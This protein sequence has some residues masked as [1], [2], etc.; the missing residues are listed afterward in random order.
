ME[1]SG[2]LISNSM[3]EIRM[4]KKALL[5]L[6]IILLL[7]TGVPFTNK[8]SSDDCF[9]Q[10]VSISLNQASLEIGE[11]LQLNVVY[12]LYYDISNP[13]GI[14]SVTVTINNQAES[15]TLRLVE[16]T[17]IGLDIQKIVELDILPDDW[18][19]YETGQ[20]GRI[21][22]EGWVQ[23]SGGTMTDSVEQQFLVQRS[24]LEITL[25]P[26]PAQI[27]FHDTINFEGFL[28]NPHNTS[29][30]VPNHPIIILATTEGQLVQSW[31]QNTTQQSNF[32]QN[33]D[34][35]LLGTGSFDCNITTLAN[36]DY[37][38]NWSLVSFF[39]SN[40]SLTLTALSN[41]S[42]V[43][44]YYPSMNNCSVLVSAVL[45]CTT[46]SHTFEGNTVTCR[47]RNQTE[48]MNYI[49][50]NLFSTELLVPNSPGNYSIVITVNAP[51]HELINTTIP[52]QVE[53]RQ[54]LMIFEANQSIAAYGDKIGFTLTVYDYW[55]RIPVE[56]KICSI[57]LY[58]QSTWNLLTQVILDQNGSANFTWLAQNVGDEDF[59]FKAIFQGT[60][61]FEVNETELIITNTQDTR[62]ILNS[63][64]SV[65]RQS[66][67]VYLL[68]I[69]TLD[70]QPLSNV[71]MQL[72]EI[73]T[74][75]TWATAITNSS[76]YAVLMWYIEPDYALGI[77][78]FSL[79]AHDGVQ[80]LG[81]LPITMIVFE[82]TIL[83]W[84]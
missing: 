38:T 17:E 58:N 24:H 76:G 74:N 33:I 63:T 3:L 66:D 77:H 5:P 35:T 83:I 8:V 10:I 29:L 9:V 50:P 73:S 46:N 7:L 23:D 43:Q 2:V 18:A 62:F 53:P 45:N 75:S 51:H 79:I 52:I 37:S 65:T 25:Y 61:E 59:R 19:P 31:N 20:I 78:K 70:Y 34:T 60:P 81:I 30:D 42:I 36:D 28:Q 21:S 57:F 15:I 80:T 12:D 14:G 39:I 40:A 41:A 11:T 67:V 55:S 22:V 32:T 69:T 4:K 84:V 13:L 6:L 64:I 26:L 54:T 44:A 1:I 47:L 49:G 82:H 16:F 72:I 27:S 56:N 48:T 71:D 68:Q